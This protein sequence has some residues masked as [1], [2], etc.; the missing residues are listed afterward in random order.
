MA[1]KTKSSLA[2]DHA[3]FLFN[4]PRSQQKNDL[5]LETQLCLWMKG[6]CFEHKFAMFNYHVTLTNKYTTQLELQLNL[7]GERKQQNK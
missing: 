5:N 6:A 2:C 3:V 7:V 1:N 4:P